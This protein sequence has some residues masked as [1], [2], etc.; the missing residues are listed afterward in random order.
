MNSTSRGRGH[1]IF[2]PCSSLFCHSPRALFPSTPQVSRRSPP[3]VSLHLPLPLRVPIPHHL[4]RRFIRPAAH[5]L[6]CVAH[7][8]KNTAHVVLFT[9][10]SSLCRSLFAVS[11]T[12]PPPLLRVSALHT[13]PQRLV[14]ARGVLFEYV[15][16]QNNDANPRSSRSVS[17]LEILPPLCR[18]RTHTHTTHALLLSSVQQSG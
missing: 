4:P 8:L 11:C 1:F 14:Q 13:L 7:H 12:S 15:P 3:A 9:C 2:L 16:H 18:A 17:Y 10:G 5:F 6:E